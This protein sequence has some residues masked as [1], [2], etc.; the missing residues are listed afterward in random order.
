[1][2][3][4]LD[5]PTERLG[6]LAN[7]SSRRWD[8]AVDESLDGDGWTL[9]LDGPQTYL[10][11]PL[12]DLSVLSKMLRFL[13][14]GPGSNETKSPLHLGRFGSS[15]IPLVWENE[16]S[17][18]CFPVIGPRAGA[19]LRLSREADDIAMLRDALQQVLNA[20][21]QAADPESP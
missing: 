6:L 21:P 20:L 17:P 13:Q 9:E 7:G 15:A 4:V 11:F 2:R 14:E 10:V 19:T 12:R 1:M 8:V 3:N 18:R 5:L 16:N